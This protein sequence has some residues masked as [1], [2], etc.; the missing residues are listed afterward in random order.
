[1]RVNILDY[2]KEAVTQMAVYYTPDW[3]TRF[4]RQGGMYGAFIGDE[5]VGVITL[6]DG[7]VRNLFIRIDYQCCGIGARLLMFIE[8]LAI[9]KGVRRLF[10]SSN[11]A[12]VKF[13]EKAGYNTIEVQK[14]KIGGS[15]IKTV[16]MEK[17]LPG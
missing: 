7:R 13:Y 9:K 3:I 12:A 14:E 11:I 8:D 6:D 2:G 4:I 5:V 1:M 15:E 16:I 10:L 17:I